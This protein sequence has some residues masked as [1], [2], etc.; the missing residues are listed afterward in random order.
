[1]LLKD[2]AAQVQLRLPKRKEHDMKRKWIAVAVAATAVL[3]TAAWAQMGP[4]MMGGYG[5]G[6]GM[7]HGYG[8]G[9]YGMGHGMMHGYGPG[10]PGMM[11][12]YGPGSYGG[13]DLSDAQRTRIGEIQKEVAR[14]QWEVMGKMHDQG[15]HMHQFA[16]PGPLDEDAARKSFQAMTDAHKAMFEATLEARKRIESVLTKEQLEQLRRNWRGG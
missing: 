1:M 6:P 8:P 15:F 7:M 10:G 9:G 13:L 12:G 5:M 4:G 3:A 14:K 11:G 16:G 2:R